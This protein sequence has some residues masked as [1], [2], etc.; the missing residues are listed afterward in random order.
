MKAL[1]PMLTGLLFV[2]ALE[3]SAIA[4]EQA[5]TSQTTT[6]A[7]LAPS[8]TRAPATG[9]TRATHTVVLSDGQR[10]VGR[11]TE[12]TSAW[13]TLRLTDGR[14]LL[15]SAEAIR[16]IIPFEPKLVTGAW[17]PDPN[18]SRYLYSPTAFSLGQGHGYLAQRAIAITSAAVGIFDFL[19]FEAGIVL[20]ALFTQTPVLTSGAKLAAP[21]SDSL[22]IGTGAQ[23]FWIDTVAAGFGF[24]NA[25]VGSP[26]AHLTVA[27]GGA[28]EFTKGDLGAGV[29]TLSGNLRL[30]PSVALI[31]ENWFLYFVRSK[32]PWGGPFF[33]VPSAGVRLFGT[34][35]A[36]DLALV[37]IVTGKSS[38]PLIPLPWISFAWNWSLGSAR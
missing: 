26:D 31:S 36:V 1:V 22:R 29:L 11:V 13:V 37:P 38:A 16:E 30:G 17:G 7:A 20:P 8:A 35:F 9:S 21:L 4:Q 25:T 19:D 15:L 3:G 10:L 27:G 33:A 5:P 2:I 6:P 18:R 28:I 24:I 32:G 14:T 23:V 12:R 34:E